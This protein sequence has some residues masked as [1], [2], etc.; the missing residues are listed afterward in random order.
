MMI[1]QHDTR[2]KKG[3]LH[4]IRGGW[5]GVTVILS[6]CFLIG[7]FWLGQMVGAGAS[8]VPGSQDDPLVTASWVEARL[9]E[10]ARDPGGAPVDLG[11]VE[12]RLDR[13]ERTMAGLGELAK[14]APPPR[15]EV[16]QV[17]SGSTVYTGQSTEVVVRAGSVRVVEGPGG[18]FSDLTGGESLL[19]GAGVK[20]NHLLLSPRQDG[21]GLA[22]RS[23]AL[24]L[25]RGSYEIK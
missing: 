10:L 11:D 21:R 5:R 17:S 14:P 7:G 4:R 15:F 3:L 24:L 13:L 20:L 16:V 9:R 18:G 12:G 19:S 22:A 23:D 6:I 8:A 25:I 2:E 1:S